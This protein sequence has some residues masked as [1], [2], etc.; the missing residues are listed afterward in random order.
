MKRKAV[1]K[2]CAVAMTVAMVG[3]LVACGNDAGNN[4]STPDTTPQESAGGEESTGAEESTGGEQ[5]TAG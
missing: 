5:A 4:S 1:M 2:L 3:G